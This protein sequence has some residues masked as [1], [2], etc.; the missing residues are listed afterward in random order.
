MGANRVVACAAAAL[1]A[2]LPL[3]GCGGEGTFTRCTLSACTVTFQR[4][5]D[6]SVEILGVEAR[7]VGVRG[8]RA[9]L[10]VAGQQITLP[11]GQGIEIAGLQVTLQRLTEQQAVVRISAAVEEDD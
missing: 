3:A 1:L 6:A 4:G 7:L 9:T 11:P 5:V 2:V 10:E 8:G